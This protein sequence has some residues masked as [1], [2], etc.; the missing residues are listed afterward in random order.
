[1]FPPHKQ[2]I[3]FI[4]NGASVLQH[5]NGAEIDSGKYIVARFNNFKIS[6]FEDYVGT[7]TQLHL[8]RSCDD[9]TMYPPQYFTKIINF[10]TYGKWT[11]GMR[12]VAQ[13][14]KGVYRDNIINVPDVEC[15]GYGTAAKLE[16]PNIEWASIGLLALAWFTTHFPDNK[17]TAIGFEFLKAGISGPTHYFAKPPKD[18]CYHNADKEENYLR[19]L[20]INFLADPL[21]SL[22]S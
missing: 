3:L 20:P 10:V 14:L 4:G 18:A 15:A 21:T 6:G 12:T 7:K 19:T 5:K 2:H 13:N 1:M 9:V 22:N 11:A 16:Q 8:R 17:F